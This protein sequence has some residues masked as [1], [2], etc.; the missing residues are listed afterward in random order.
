MAGKPIT[1]LRDFPSVEEIMQSSSLADVLSVV[2]RPVAVVVVRGVIAARKESFRADRKPLTEDE[3]ISAVKLGIIAA[4]RQE[5]GQV[6]NATG[7]VVHTNLGRAPLSDAIF[8]AI[9]KTVTG[10][11]NIEFDL[12]S[13]TRG[14][15]GVACERYL[16]LL[17]G[18][19][20]GTVVN[21]CAAAL[22]LALN[23]LAS[24]KSV[25][26]S[27]GELVQIGGGFRIPDILRKSGARLCEIGSTNI[28][29][30]DDYEGAIDR[31]TGLILKVHKSNFVQ[32]G[33]TEEVPLKDLVELGRRYDIPVF[34][35]LGSGVFVNTRPLL[36][37]AEPTVQ[38]SVSAGADLTSFSG[39]K[40]LGGSQAGLLVGRAD[41][42]ARVKKNPIFRTMRVDKITYSIIEKMLA[43]Y[44]NTSHERDIALWRLLSVSESVLYQRG[45]AVLAS[46]GNPSGLSIEATRVYIGGGA[47]PQSDLPS[48]GI[49]FSPDYKPNEL[50][51][52][53]REGTP[54]VIGRIENDRLVLDLKAID[55][56]DLEIV[57][58]AIRSIVQ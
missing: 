19:E 3:V 46:L 13:G 41:L 53:L 44:L 48:V 33:F 2:P 10:Y 32:A 58:E 4:A 38:Q 9:K 26:I 45:K 18:A 49:V 34:N 39:D 16:A 8:D 30:L 31:G 57:T 35:D 56:G 52:R 14:K 23:T 20:A 28:T 51:R 37:Y 22:F 36:G 6:I 5:I 55:E 40:L 25:I 43:I 1:A 11:G 47:L 54:P 17:S 15:R 7:I 27:R 24:R 50:L 29:T 12:L 42:V 21:N